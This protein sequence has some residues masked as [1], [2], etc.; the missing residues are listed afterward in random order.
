[1]TAKS[2]GHYGLDLAKYESKLGYCNRQ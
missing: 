1:M 2:L